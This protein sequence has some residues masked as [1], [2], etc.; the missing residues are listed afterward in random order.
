MF[1]SI[2]HTTCCHIPEDHTVQIFNFIIK[3]LLFIS[4]YVMAVAWFYV[5]HCLTNCPPNG[6]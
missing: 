2:Y 4:F 3:L 1:M 5:E 6:M